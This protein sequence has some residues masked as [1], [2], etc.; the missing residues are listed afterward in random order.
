MVTTKHCCWG[1]CKSDSR[2][3]CPQGVYF[4][5]FGNGFPKPHGKDTEKCLR[6]V[7][8]CGRKYFTIKNVTKDTY[9][10]SLHF[11]GGNGPTDE[12]P[13]PNKCG[14]QVRKQTITFV[15]RLVFVCN[16]ISR[17]LF[18]CETVLILK[19]MKCSDIY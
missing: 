6:W 16:I 12:Y 9:M 7:E 5:G 2:T 4:I 18:T 13:D 19:F 10:C 14:T 8:S 11:V 1:D 3:G 17:I 15:R